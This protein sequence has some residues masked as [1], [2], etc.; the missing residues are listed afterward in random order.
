[1]TMP[2]IS[3]EGASHLEALALFSEKLGR[4]LPPLPYCLSHLL[5][6]LQRH[7]S[8]PPVLERVSSNLEAASHR[9][10]LLGQVQ[11]SLNQV[12]R[13]CRVSYPHVASNLHL[14]PPFTLFK[15]PWSLPVS[16]SRPTIHWIGRDY[17]DTSHL[18]WP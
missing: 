5:L 15:D 11:A 12:W 18:E 7:A 6:T 2:D 4:V 10:L 16:L 3:Q 8:L 9:L 1:M 13:V 17:G 14:L